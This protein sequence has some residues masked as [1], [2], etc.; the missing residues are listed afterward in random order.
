MTKN[1]LKET[2]CK[3]RWDWV[4]GH[5]DREKAYEDLPFDAQLNVQVNYLA[6]KSTSSI[7]N[8]TKL[9]N[10]GDPSDNLYQ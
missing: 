8:F 7:I 10:F 6:K 5:Q 9:S 3:I 2:D 4:K 1:T